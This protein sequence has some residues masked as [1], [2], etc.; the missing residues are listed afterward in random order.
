MSG[1]AWNSLL[2]NKI[3]ENTAPRTVYIYIYTC[4]GCAAGRRGSVEEIRR[5]LA[6]IDVKGAAK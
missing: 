4:I 1:E 2:Q 6:S 3:I 5:D